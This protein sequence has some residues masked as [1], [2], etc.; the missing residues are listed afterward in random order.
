MIDNLFQ[1]RVGSVLANDTIHTL[2]YGFEELFY[3]YGVDLEFWAHEHNYERLWPVYNKKVFN[4]SLEEP[5]K[6]PKA[7]VH[8]ITGSAVSIVL[9]QIFFLRNSDLFIF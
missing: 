1:L 4:G 9:N 5:Y 6:N 8:I 7:P 3:K 2:G